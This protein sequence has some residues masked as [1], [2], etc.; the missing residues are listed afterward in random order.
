MQNYLNIFSKFQWFIGNLAIFIALFVPV[1]VLY[2]LE[3]G[4]EYTVWYA[5]ADVVIIF[6]AVLSAWNIGRKQLEQL[7]EEVEKTKDN[8]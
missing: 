7:K 4:I 1:Q 3:H 6:A 8:Q 5:V 2:C